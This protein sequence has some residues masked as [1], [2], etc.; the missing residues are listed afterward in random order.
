MEQLLD[1]LKLMIVGMGMVFTFLLI[2]ILWIVL[3]AKISAKFAYLL[4]ETPVKE[5]GAKRKE[6]ESAAP[7]KEDE[8]L[9]SVIAAA[10]Q[11]Y[12][13]DRKD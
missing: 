9:V 6:G 1:G 12:R 5:S 11:R 7:G 4:P 2:M 8:N 10:I 3:S 13:A